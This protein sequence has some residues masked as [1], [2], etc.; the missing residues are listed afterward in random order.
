MSMMLL[1]NNIVVLHFR[2]GDILLSINDES[3]IG[4]S[5]ERAE[6]CLKGLPRGPFRLTV[7]PPPRDV[8]GEGRTQPEPPS[9]VQQPPKQ[10]STPPDTQSDSHREE[11]NVIITE[12]LQV[13]PGSSVGF[14]IE[15][16]SDTPLMYVYIKSLVLDSPAHICGQFNQGDQL[17]MVG[18]ACLIGMTHYDAKQILESAPATVEVVAQRKGFTSQNGSS[19][20]NDTTNSTDDFK[21]HDILTPS[22]TDDL[23]IGMLESTQGADIVGIAD[24]LKSQD[25][26]I[27]LG[28]TDDLKTDV[29]GVSTD[30]LKSDLLASGVELLGSS[31]SIKDLKA[32]IGRDVKTDPHGNSQAQLCPEETTTV[33]LI[34]GPGEKLGIGIVGGSDN[35]KLKDVHVSSHS[36]SNV[37]IDSCWY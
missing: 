27:M 1:L 14:E 12:T 24:D 20:S 3:T 9:P 25:A 4:L 30:D 13:S 5:V 23:K 6:A 35:P 22:K 18:D 28:S 11:A 8:T 26:D 15:G 37:A 2:V 21:T 16:G 36:N 19:Q 31:N 7:M 33:E 29:L 34:R 17:I 32:N 10:L